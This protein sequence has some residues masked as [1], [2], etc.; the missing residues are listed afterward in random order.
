M[1][2]GTMANIMGAM[3]ATTLTDPKGRAS[4]AG[5]AVLA[6]AVGG[7]LVLAG[8]ARLWA[9]WQAEPARVGLETVQSSPETPHPALL[10]E[11]AQSLADAG[12]LGPVIVPWATSDQ[13][14]SLEALMRIS[15]GDPAGLPT[16]EAALRAA[17]GDPNGWLWLARLRAK[18]GNLAAAGQAL[19]VS[20]LAG[21][22]LPEK[23]RGRLRLALDLYPTL[24]ADTQHL[25]QRQVGLVWVIY[26]QDIPA[27]LAVQAYRSVIIEALATATATDEQQFRRVNR[28]DRSPSPQR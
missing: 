11:I 7:L 12:R 26:P 1:G 14:G 24:D 19:R 15:A 6:V 16:L 5:A 13:G 18:D 27:L 10:L 17:P 8:A 3:A 23:M 22:V 28:L 21:Q 20:L 25:I 2:M 4:G 9:V